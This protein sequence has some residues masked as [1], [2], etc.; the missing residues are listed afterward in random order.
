M[1]NAIWLM[2]IIGSVIIAVF[3]GNLKAVTASATE[4]A[5]AAFKLAIGFT[6]VMAL[7]LGIMRIAQDSGLIGALTKLITP[8]MRYLFPEVPK[9]NP[10]MGSM[11][12]NMVANMFG[13]NNAATPLGIKAMHRLDDLNPNKGTATHAM[14]MFLA[15]NT[16]SLQIIP[17]G[18]IALLSA[19]GS[20][21]PT[22]IVFP[23]ILATTVSTVVGISS[24]RMMSKLKVFSDPDERREP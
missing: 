23:A 16:S 2:L 22:S 6:G 14:C 3:T 24:A 21:D 5:E 8:A 18:A 10:A 1:L 4:S 20:S 7:W 12:M 15:I 13:L 11:A 19:G 17:A 9:D